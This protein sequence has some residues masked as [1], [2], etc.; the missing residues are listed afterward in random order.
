[1][2][3]KIALA[4]LVGAL[5]GMLAGTRGVPWPPSAQG[6]KGY[7]AGTV[8]LVEAAWNTARRHIAP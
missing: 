7:G 4:A 3:V 5:S 1:M 2:I 6:Q 8:A